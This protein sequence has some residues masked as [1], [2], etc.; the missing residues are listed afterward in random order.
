[1]GGEGLRG[2]PFGGGKM[3]LYPVIIQDRDSYGRFH[4]IP[5]TRLYSCPIHRWE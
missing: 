2:D 3:V 5:R 4:N 1:M